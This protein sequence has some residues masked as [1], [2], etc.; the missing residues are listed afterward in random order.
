MPLAEWHGVSTDKLGRVIELELQSRSNVTPSNNL[1]GHIPPEL[2]KL[3]KL[4][5]LDL[6]FNY[7][8]GHI[9]AELG[10]LSNLREMKLGHNELFEEI[11]HSL[12]NL[13]DLEQI[14]FGS[15]W[16]PWAF[17]ASHEVQ[18]W[19]KRV[20]DVSDLHQL[21]TCAEPELK[22][23]L[24]AIYHSTGGETWTYN[25][26]WLTYQPISD[27]FGIET[28]DKGNVIGLDLARNNLTGQIPPES[29]NLTYLNHL[30]LAEN[31]LS[32]PVPSELGNLQIGYLDLP[33]N[34]LTGPVPT[35]VLTSVGE[36]AFM[37]NLDLCIPASA[38]DLYEQKRR[39]YDE[40][41]PAVSTCPW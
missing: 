8:T 17:C 23:T 28:D 34:D 31:D 12:A 37:G 39:K 13:K 26:G 41:L 35:V 10:S 22:E 25:F 4:R 9:P 19:L 36:I 15:N 5:K 24:D 40:L 38:R 20:W 18:D 11:P 32:G 16:N 2:A 30:N 21:Q 3:S 33:G 7:L 14:N 29:G 1:T 27:W 6:E